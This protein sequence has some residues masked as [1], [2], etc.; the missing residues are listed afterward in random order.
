MKA[1]ATGTDEKVTKYRLDSRGGVGLMG[2]LIFYHA[3]RIRVVS[4][5]NS[6]SKVDAATMRVRP[7]ASAEE[8][9]PKVGQVTLGTLGSFDWPGKGWHAM[10][11]ASAAMLEAAD[12][13]IVAPHGLVVV[14]GVGPIPAHKDE[15]LDITL[16]AKPS[17]LPHLSGEVAATRSGV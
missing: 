10:A 12:G 8:V 3:I 14:V 15:L 7:A 11:V 4:V 13:L 9:E 6:T 2:Y 5:A 17:A 16:N 1:V